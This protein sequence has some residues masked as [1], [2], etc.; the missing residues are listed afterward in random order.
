[1]F[2]TLSKT[3]I[4]IYHTFILSSENAFSLDK[5]KFVLSE[6]GLRVLRYVFLDLGEN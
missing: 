1:M 5:V 3:E 2:S 4:I 6:N